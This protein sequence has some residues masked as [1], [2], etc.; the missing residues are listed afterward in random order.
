[1]SPVAGTL[2][3][4]VPSAFS[5]TGTTLPFTTRITEEIL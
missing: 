4:Y 5:L 2:I 1:M 3:R